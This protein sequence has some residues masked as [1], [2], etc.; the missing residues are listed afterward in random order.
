MCNV[1]YIYNPHYNEA[2]VPPAASTAPRLSRRT[3]ICHLTWIFVSLLVVWSVTGECGVRSADN[4]PP[5]VPVVAAQSED[6]VPTVSRLTQVYSVAVSLHS[7][8]RFL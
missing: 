1:S 4:S 2:I 3:D 6:V 7:G 8:E 5:A